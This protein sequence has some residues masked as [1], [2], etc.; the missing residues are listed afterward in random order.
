MAEDESGIDQGKHSEGT[1]DREAPTGP[2]AFVDQPVGRQQ[3]QWIER[4]RP[5]LGQRIP[6]HVDIDHVER[7]KR[8]GR[9]GQQTRPGR[10]EPAPPKIEHAQPGDGKPGQLRQ[11]DRPDEAETQKAKGG[12]DVDRERR[13]IVIEWITIAEIGVGHPA[14]GEVTAGQRG[15]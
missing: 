1:A 13:V 12:G 11:M 15:R 2:A 9:G 5:E 14:H 7:G 6:A 10:S 3:D 8:V 4:H